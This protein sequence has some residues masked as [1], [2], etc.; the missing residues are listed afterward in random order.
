[1]AAFLNKFLSSLRP[2]AHIAIF[3]NPRSIMLEAGCEKGRLSLEVM[4]F[5]RNRLF[6][7]PSELPP[8]TSQSGRLRLNDSAGRHALSI[9]SK[10]NVRGGV[11]V[12]VNATAF[13]SQFPNQN[14][15]MLTYVAC[16]RYCILWS[17]PAWFMLRGR[18]HLLNVEEDE[19]TLAH[20]F[21]SWKA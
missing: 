2:F 16:I 10:Q 9:L 8:S 12:N 6:F 13:V 21:P 7:F 1:M 17:L 19:K 4:R 3:E 11:A 5:S 14:C 15:T 18:L 20:L